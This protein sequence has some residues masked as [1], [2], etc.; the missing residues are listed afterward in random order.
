MVP[1][2]GWGTEK[3]EKRDQNIDKNPKGDIL[4]VDRTVVVVNQFVD[5]TSSFSTIQFSDPGTASCG[6]V[7]RSR[8]PHFFV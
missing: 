7:W 2:E 8:T 1:W 3:V 5:K 6:T 4:L